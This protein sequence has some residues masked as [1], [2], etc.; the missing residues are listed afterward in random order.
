MIQYEKDIRTRSDFEKEVNG[1]SQIFAGKS[2]S[3]R[4]TSLPMLKI[5]GRSG[6]LQN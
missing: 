6:F 5:S 3:G 4:L 2:A 1:S